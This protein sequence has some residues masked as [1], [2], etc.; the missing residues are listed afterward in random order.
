MRLSELGI[1]LAGVHSVSNLWID[2]KHY[3]VG[4]DGDTLV[5]ADETPRQESE[6]MH[7]VTVASLSRPC[8]YWAGGGRLCKACAQ[9]IGEDGN[10]TYSCPLCATFDRI[11]PKMTEAEFTAPYVVPKAAIAWFDSFLAD[12]IKG[13]SQM[14]EKL[15]V[16]RGL[17]NSMS[18]KASDDGI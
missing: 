2:G 4:D 15:G 14:A 3:E 12:E 17:L 10:G 6:R 16:P 8:V 1:S 5:A 9:P 11:G 13:E 18:R 7:S